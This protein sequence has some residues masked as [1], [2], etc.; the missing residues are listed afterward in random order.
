M[1][2]KWPEVDGDML[3]DNL[4]EIPIQINGRVRDRVKIERGISEENVM[5]KV[6]K[7]Q[8]IAELLEGVEIKKFIY[9]DG[10]IVNIIT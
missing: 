3:V 7:K 8:K 1:E 4:I 10:K 2:N 6:L 9:V 5:G